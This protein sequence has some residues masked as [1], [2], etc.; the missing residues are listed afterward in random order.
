M[1]SG[2]SGSP[3]SSRSSYTTA[4]VLVV[5][6]A[7]GVSARF[8]DVPLA[9][10][11]LIFE[12][13]W[14]NG[15]GT[16][17]N[18]I[19][20][21]G[22]WPNYWEFN[23][24]SS[25]QLL[26]VVTGG[27]DGQNALRV[28]QRGSSYAAN[29]QLDNFNAQSTDYYLR[30]YM[31]NDDTSSAGDHIATVDTF[32]YANLTFMRKTGSGSS[33]KF[34]I[35]LYGCGYTYPIGH[36]GPSQSLANGQW[37]RF[38]Y[39]VDFRSSNQVQVH[40]RVYDAAGNLIMSDASFQQ[41]DFGGATWNGRSD[42]TLASY[43]A[44]GNT[45]CVNPGWMNDL[46]LGNNGQ[47]GAADTGK[48]W[49]FAGVQLRSDTWPGPLGSGGGGGGGDTTPPTVSLTAP[50][51]GATVSGTTVISATASDDVGVAGVQFKVNG[52]NMGAEDTVAPYSYSWD[53]TAAANAP[54]TLTAV[55]RDAAGNQTVSATR[56][57][58]VSNGGGDTT[59]PTVSLTA[60]ASGA[61]VSGTTVISA[62]ASDNVSVVGVQFKVNGNNM[63]AEDTVAP[64]SYS[65]D[66]LAA[67]NAPHT[68][69]A[70]ARDAAGNQTTSAARTVTVSNTTTPPPPS[71]TGIAS[72]YPRDVGIESDPDVIFV[73]KFEEPTLTDLFNR[74]TDILRGSSM[75]FSTD[76]VPESTGT[77]SLN[78]PWVGGG[79]NEGG[80]LY[81]VLSPGI[82]DQVFVRYYIKYPTTGRYRH[83]GIWI[84]GSNPVSSWPNPQA[85]TKPA[86]NDRFIAG[87]EQTDDTSR[88]DHYDYWMNMRIAGDG[89]YWG[90]T[91][92][93]NP[94]VKARTGQWMCVE[95][96][97][98]LNNPV[99][100]FNGEHAIWLDGVKVSHLG[101]GFPNGT[102]SGGNFTQSSSGSPFEGFR[103]RSDANLKVNWIWLQ[104][105]A[106]D[107]PAGFTSSIKFDHVVVA[108][109]YIGCLST[110]PAAPRPAFNVRVIR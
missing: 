103:W 38:E 105:Y 106:P 104:N 59:P 60:P 51:A 45:F 94:N 78:I 23:G 20:D 42:W 68:L 95:H 76:V 67:A 53:T 90:N 57:V 27:P 44:A 77:R 18:A 63:G 107:D 75:T 54:H 8:A 39:F 36:W 2:R 85:G 28:Q 5:I 64:Y 32:N 88:F 87:A 15:T 66:T 52:N 35:S 83:E 79:V 46:G 1:V 109:S 30:Y 80:H 110:G 92:L 34:V 26:S 49:Y 22:R 3:P 24:G 7:G 61:T 56:T 86:G 69:T 100:S 19:T 37:Y 55:A 102:W 93:G 98:K 10:P 65:W 33:F 82:D 41:T 101:Q 16:S 25:V 72:R 47:L 48:Y 71:G 29:V 50:A 73:E 84:G 17:S 43:Y 13:N 14:T 99:T 6:L 96:M 74:W 97:V 11:G 4:L 40:P 12:S 89:K 21:G 31:K 91:L 70:V 62:T 81:K 108:R 58:T 9:D